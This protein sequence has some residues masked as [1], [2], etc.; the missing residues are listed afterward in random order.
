M[1]AARN[2]KCR[3]HTKKGKPC[4]RYAM[5]GG[6]VCYH[7]GGATK[8]AKAKAAIRSA[9][10]NWGLSDTT[11]DPGEVLLRLVTQSSIRVQ[12]YAEEIAQLVADEPVLQK[13]LVGD[14]WGESGKSG[15]YI[16]GIVRLEAAERDRCA[17]FCRLAIAA[18]L[19]ERQVKL[20]ERQGQVLSALLQT[21]L[22]DPA[23]GL[24]ATQQGSIPSV[25]RTH[26]AAIK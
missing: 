25:I 19:A 26:L 9:V 13:A 15:E 18:G 11:V 8:Q 14:S 5:N 7:H 16:R 6:L 12:R 20:A 21:V 2:L 17:N 23:L 4:T 10:T 22:A 1:P 24:T 3:A